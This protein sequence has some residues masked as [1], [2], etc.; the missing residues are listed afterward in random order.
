MDREQFRQTIIAKY[1]KVDTKVFNNVSQ[2]VGA[3]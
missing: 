1:L 3:S 2:L